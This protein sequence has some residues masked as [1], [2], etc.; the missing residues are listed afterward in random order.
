MTF[1]MRKDN[2]NKVDR[3][4]WI[5]VGDGRALRNCTLIDISDSG[6]KLALE[7]EVDEIPDKF[8]LWLS[9]HGH[10]HY[11]C[12]VVWSHQ[13]NIGVQFSSDDVS[14]R[15]RGAGQPPGRTAQ[16]SFSARRGRLELR[17][18]HP[19]RLVFSLCRRESARRLD[20]T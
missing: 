20:L 7:E 2:R 1:R 6:A 17:R 9:R 10:P 8:S 5:S 11:S 18:D 13:N 14:A 12:Q 16:D 3:I 15:G 4:A 19:Y